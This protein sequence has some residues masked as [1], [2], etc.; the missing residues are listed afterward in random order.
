MVGVS[1]A[2]S[3]ITGLVNTSKNL[4]NSQEVIRY[5]SEVFTRS[6]KQTLEPVV[7]TGVDQLTVLQNAGATTCSGQQKAA[8]FTEVFTLDGDK[9]KCSIDAAVPITILTGIETMTFGLTANQLFSVTVKP[10]PLSGEATNAI[11]IDI[12]LSGRIL[13]NV[14]GS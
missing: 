6:L 14:L 7:V 5:S 4:E 9:L 13:I 8:A 2:Y 12:A 11:K 3:S 1:L 10:L